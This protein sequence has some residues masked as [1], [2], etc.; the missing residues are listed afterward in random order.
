MSLYVDTRMIL[1]VRCSGSHCRSLIRLRIFS[2]RPKVTIPGNIFHS[3]SVGMPSIRFTSLTW[4]FSEYH[5]ILLLPVASGSSPSVPTQSTRVGED[6]GFGVEDLISLTAPYC[7]ISLS[8][9]TYN[10]WNWLCLHQ[11]LLCSPISCSFSLNY[12]P[13]LF[14]K[15]FFTH[16]RLASWS[17][18]RW[19]AARKVVFINMHH[20]AIFTS[21]SS[22]GSSFFSSVDFPDDR[23]DCFRVITVAG[24][25]WRFCDRAVLSAFGLH[26]WSDLLDAKGFSVAVLL[27]N[28]LPVSDSEKSTSPDS[29]FVAT[30][31]SVAV[32]INPPRCASSYSRAWELDAASDFEFLLI[33]LSN[34]LRS[35]ECHRTLGCIRTFCGCGTC[36]NM[37]RLDHRCRFRFRHTYFFSFLFL[38]PLRQRCRAACQ[39]G[40]LSAASRA[41]MADAE[42]LKK[43]VSFVTCELTFG[44]NVCELMFGINVSNLNLRIKIKPDTQPIQS[45]SVVSWHMSHCGTSTLHYL[46]HHGFKDKQHSIGTRM[47]SVW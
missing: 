32:S 8:T 28:G 47:C 7:T 3:N 25:T 2:R 9:S 20:I 30:G 40:I 15:W 22:I 21:R 38:H 24:D 37:W 42:P 1:S 23:E 6:V 43:I 44:R 16:R 27:A 17:C 36:R 46:L 10:L 26:R 12:C 14:R 29:S 45:H 4:L 31:F 34:F 33:L 11:W 13:T 41:E 5:L 19:T 18:P 35:H 39:A